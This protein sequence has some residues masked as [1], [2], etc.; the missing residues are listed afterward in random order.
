MFVG[1]NRS[2]RLALGRGGVN[3]RPRFRCCRPFPLQSRCL[4]AFKRVNG[5]DF[6]LE[7]IQDK[8]SDVG[9]KRMPAWNRRYHDWR[10]N[11]SMRTG[12]FLRIARK[13]SMRIMFH[14]FHLLVKEFLAADELG[15]VNARWRVLWMR[16]CSHTAATSNLISNKPVDR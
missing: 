13:T 1:I 2:K 10:R 7:N 12:S 9:C 8:V 6:V 11:K 14:V 5:S 16:T 15:Y 3:R 4:R